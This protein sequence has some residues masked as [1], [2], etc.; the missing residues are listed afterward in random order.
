[1]DLSDILNNKAAIFLRDLFQYEL[2]GILF[3]GSL[4]IVIKNE[5][6]NWLSIFHTQDILWSVVI[7]ISFLVLAFV[8]GQ[9]L[10]TL[11]FLLFP[12]YK[13]LAK[14]LFYKKRMEKNISQ[15]KRL[16]QHMEK[17]E[18]DNNDKKIF[19]SMP[20]HLYYE[21]FT[22]IN[23]N[24]LHT[25]FIE[26]YNLFMFMRRTLSSYLFFIG[27]IYLYFLPNSIFFIIL[28]AL[29]FILSYLLFGQFIKTNSDFLER[30][31][32]SYLISRDKTN[33]ELLP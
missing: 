33:N 30:V 4:L 27:V 8:V 29:I 3:I 18:I 22:Y 24:D 14:I 25:R 28:K 1:M 9:I 13:K 10:Y 32:T 19:L 17:L 7:I 23:R 21:M 2:S 6:F 31:F 12:I 15:K 5:E 11:S 16:V 20:E 26:R